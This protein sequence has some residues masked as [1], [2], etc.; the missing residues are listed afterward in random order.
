MIKKNV[1][2]MKQWNPDQSKIKTKERRKI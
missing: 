2:R 1:L